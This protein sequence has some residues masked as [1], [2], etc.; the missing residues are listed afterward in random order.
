MFAI[1]SSIVN[2]VPIIVLQ[3]TPSNLRLTLVG[4]CPEFTV[5]LQDD[6]TGAPI[7]V[8]APLPL[9]GPIVIS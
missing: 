7:Q 5:L 1:Q 8:G 2:L 4:C 9:H 6:P 3:L